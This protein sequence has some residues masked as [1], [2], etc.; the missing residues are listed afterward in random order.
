MTQPAVVK[1]E[2]LAE[3]VDL[4]TYRKASPWQGTLAEQVVAEF[5]E[6]QQ[7]SNHLPSK[8]RDGIWR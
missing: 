8:G 4:A 5:R 1:I 3:V 6:L 2:K 7:E